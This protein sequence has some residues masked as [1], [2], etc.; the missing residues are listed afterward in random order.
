LLIISLETS[1]KKLAALAAHTFRGSFRTDAR[2]GADA[3]IGCLLRAPAWRALE[4]YEQI[5]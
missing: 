4:T 1:V 5:L 3:A 2:S